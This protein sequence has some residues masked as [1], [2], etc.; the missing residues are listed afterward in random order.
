MTDINFQKEAWECLETDT[1]LMVFGDLTG[2]QN[3]SL[4]GFIV[5]TSGRRMQPM[6][7]TLTCKWCKNTENI[8]MLTY[9][10]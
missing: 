9:L 5:D 10:K 1:N 2:K 4:L 6:Q 7:W 8:Q 3:T